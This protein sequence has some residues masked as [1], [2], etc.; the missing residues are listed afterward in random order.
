MYRGDAGRQ[1]A[2]AAHPLSQSGC[3][4]PFAARRPRGRRLRWTRSRW[5][6]HESELPPARN[7]K[8]PQSR[9]QRH[10]Q[11]PSPSLL[12]G[13]LAQPA[14]TYGRNPG[15]SSLSL[16]D[17][18]IELEECR[19]SCGD[20]NAG[21][22]AAIAA[23]IGQRVELRRFNHAANFQGHPRGSELATEG[24]RTRTFAP[25]LLLDGTQRES[26]DAGQWRPC[27]RDFQLKHYRFT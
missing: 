11:M 9:Q 22:E 17:K 6:C 14:C 12:A 15:A 2:A 7:A 3:H 20:V 8:H 16:G 26:G 19:S 10:G 21:V 23:A 27:A 1:A 13:R 4:S 25:A 5:W 24:D 18:S